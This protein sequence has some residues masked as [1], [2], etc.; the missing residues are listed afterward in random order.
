MIH[1]NKI[2]PI[3]FSKSISKN[4]PSGKSL[5]TLVYPV[6]RKGKTTRMSVERHLRRVCG[7]TESGN[8][9]HRTAQKAYGRQKY[10][11]QFQLIT[12][13]RSFPDD[14]C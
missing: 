13:H 7:G 3:I 1:I 5:M 2:L 9:L 10:S 6:L 11:K 14:M 12:H 8:A 4:K